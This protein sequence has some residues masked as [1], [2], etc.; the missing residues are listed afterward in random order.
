MS[1]ELGEP[2]F[3][4]KPTENSI[5]QTWREEALLLA[6]DANVGYTSLETFVK[7]YMAGRRVDST[8]KLPLTEEEI[9]YTELWIKN[10]NG[11]ISK[12]ITID[13]LSQEL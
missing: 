7:G 11:T 4:S 12:T 6:V 10:G 3:N 1:N 8:I 2:N 5:E 13:E 9:R